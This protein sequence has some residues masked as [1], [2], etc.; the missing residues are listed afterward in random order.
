MN[1][2]A[3]KKALSFLTNH[4]LFDAHHILGLQIASFSNAS[5]QLGHQDRSMLE[6]RNPAG[7]ADNSPDMVFWEYMWN[8]TEHRTLAG[9]LKILPRTDDRALDHDATAG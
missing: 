2:S 6:Y 3:W 8:V 7:L 5:R 1:S 9:L 4:V